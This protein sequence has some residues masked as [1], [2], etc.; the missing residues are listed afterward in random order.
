MYVQYTHIFSTV[1][2]GLVGTN[3][4]DLCK[5]R[6]DPDGERMAIRLAG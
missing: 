3:Q 4:V 1:K 5:V 2:D 6:I